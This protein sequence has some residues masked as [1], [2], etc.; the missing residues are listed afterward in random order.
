MRRGLGGR[1]SPVTAAG[2]GQLTAGGTPGAGGGAWRPGTR[3]AR[4]FNGCRR[5]HGLGS[6]WVTAVYAPW[7]AVTRCVWPILRGCPVA[8]AGAPGTDLPRTAITG[9]GSELSTCDSRQLV[10]LRKAAG[11]CGSSRSTC[12]ARGLETPARGEGIWC[13]MSG[14]PGFRHPLGLI[15]SRVLSRG[16]RAGGRRGGSL[17]EARLGGVSDGPAR[18]SDALGDRGRAQGGGLVSTRDLCALTG[19]REPQMGRA[20][21]S[22]SLVPSNYSYPPCTLTD[23]ETRTEMINRELQTSQR[24]KQEILA[25]EGHLAAAS[26]KQTITEN[27][28]LLLSQL[29]SL[30]PQYVAPGSPGWGRGRWSSSWASAWRQALET[31]NA[32][33]GWGRGGGAVWPS[34]GGCCRAG[35]EAAALAPGC[36]ASGSLTRSRPRGPSGDPLGGLP[37]TSWI[38]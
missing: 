12:D 23:E 2:A 4:W 27:S 34:R 21:G 38:K 3:W 25:F 11:A 31:L 22:S 1:G 14:R 8:G 33:S 30:D 6:A 24:E 29:T 7:Y 26:T 9:G 18:L 15:L 5:E 20:P 17:P 10:Y 35:R 32:L 28:S 19:G 36:R 13:R 16:R 37:P